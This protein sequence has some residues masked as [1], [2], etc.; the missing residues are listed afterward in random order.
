LDV[1]SN[2]SSDDD[3]SVPIWPFVVIPLAVLLCGAFLWYATAAWL[4]KQAAA[5][6]GKTA[7]V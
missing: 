3:S 4:K 5:E 7:D 6:D 1:E 2:I